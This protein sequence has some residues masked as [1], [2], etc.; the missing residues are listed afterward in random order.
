MT[1]SAGS[2]A[3]DPAANAFT[4]TPDELAARCPLSF[5]QQGLWIVDQLEPGR[6]VYSIPQAWRL[7]GS[8]DIPAFQQA[9]NR[10]VARH[11]TL[12]TTFGSIKGR[13]VQLVSEFQPRHFPVIDLSGAVDP[14]AAAR[15]IM[16][17]E[18]QSPFDLRRGPLFR[19]HILRL[20]ANEH[21][22]LFN[23]HHI[24]SDAQSF[25]LLRREISECY[26][27]VR[28]G[29]KAALPFLPVQ[30]LDY[31][32][33][34]RERFQSGLLE[35]ELAYWKQHLAGAAASQEF[36][37]DFSRDG[38][39]FK[40]ASERFALPMATVQALKEMS[41]RE[42]ATLFMAVLAALGALLHRWIGSNDVVVG[43]PF[44]GRGRAETE[45]LIGLFVNTLPL[46]LRVNREMAFSELL[47]HVRET[48]LG[49]FAHQETPFEEIVRAL[50]PERNLRRNPFFQVVLALQK[51]TPASWAF[52]G[53]HACLVEMDTHT[54]KFDLTLLLEETDCGIKG[55]LEY[56]TDLFEAN[57]I[58]CFLQQ[59]I[60]LIESVAEM[61]ACP[62][63]RLPAPSMVCTE[64]ARPEASA[65]D[66][67]SEYQE[68]IHRAFETQAA[69]TPDAV[70]VSFQGRTLTYAELNARANRLA[71]RLHALGVRPGVRTGVCLERSPELILSLLA[72]LKAG[73]AYVPLDPAC[74]SKRLAFLAQDA[75]LPVVIASES[76]DT[77][78][79]AGTGT[80][81]LAVNDAAIN[82]QEAGNLD[83]HAASEDPA[84]VLYTSGSTGAPKGVIV[85][86]RAVLRLV[87]GADYARFA[88]DE[89]FL[90]FAPISFD[91]S[92]FE[93]WG[94]LLNGA[95][96]EIFPPH[97]PSLAELGRVIHERA[98]TTLWLT[99]GL[100]HQMVDEQLE[101][102]RG[103]RQLLAGGDVL[104][105]PH[106]AKLIRNVPECR[107]INGYGPTE[108]TTFT[109]CFPV[110]SFWRPRRSVPIGRPIRGTQ[111]FVLDEQLEPVPTGVP[112]ELC[113]AGEGLALGYLNQPELTAERF[114]SNPFG[115]P[116]SRMYRSGDRVRL[117]PD[118]N[119]E[120]LGRMDQQV[121]IRGFRVEPGE[122]ETALRR[123]PGV[124]DAAVTARETHTGREL[125]AYVVAAGQK[126]APETLERFLR[127]KL[128]PYMMPASF[129]FL[130]A[131][132]L[133]ANGKVDYR[134]LPAPAASRGDN[135]PA[136]PV[137]ETEAILLSIW[138]EVLGRN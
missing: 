67:E 100:F 8:L 73:S 131:L 55:R 82:T 10:V 89:V 115:P 74:P 104:S 13:P 1:P 37:C 110:P 80:A 56:N 45:N 83:A 66:F 122:I 14:E 16:D 95:R 70:A 96:L 90:Q 12:R 33:W 99:A 64:P 4:G 97:M 91:A 51:G 18:A 52:G 32:L 44:S 7:E 125:V 20:S 34:Q 58:R 138:K 76:F 94:A 3:V 121:K 109:C 88:P 71:R 59:F 98:V 54:A 119:L 137:S 9:L 38:D 118:G 46:R 103:V 5:A 93:I 29:R 39:A 36:P 79:F 6:A 22:A 68:T 47:V 133:T 101:D 130:D 127:T 43:A 77:S 136:P 106:V 61:P 41:R 128:P 85:P 87:R 62:V 105:V 48:V 57:T 84:Y 78:V 81:V 63:R 19:A 2:P 65:P 49:V 40:G 60:S 132:P 31:A 135:A 86:H 15:Q 75:A 117:L 23:L 112:G 113:I 116:G 124:H 50:A 69:Q 24:V 102:L 129:V 35:R 28:A 53:L 120:F 111:V 17:D 25:E 72:I 42:G 21:L 107:L 114:V 11:E 30:Y 92:T 26:E 134:A 123:H 108:N 27:A 126:P